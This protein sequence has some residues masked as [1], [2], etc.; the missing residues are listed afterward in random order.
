MNTIAKGL[1]GLESKLR[2]PGGA[3]LPCRMTL[4]Q[5]DDGGLVMHSPIRLDDEQLA[6]IRALGPV[7]HIIAPNLYHHLFLKKAAENFPEAQV[8]LADGLPE[9]IAGLPEGRP[10]SELVASE[11]LE[12]GSLRAFAI[13]GQPKLNEF[14]FYY[15][16]SKALV[17]TDL[18]FNIREP[19]G[20]MTKLVLGMMGTKG[21]FAV[22]RLISAITKDK[23]AAASSVQAL[24]GLDVEC[25][26]P[27]HGQVQHDDARET[28]LQATAKMRKAAAVGEASV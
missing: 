27:A 23:Q 14:V 15:R 5:L 4:C 7:K 25:I 18:V 6:A 1:W 2:I 21:R 8:W 12:G 28:F 17:C 24:C 13:A 26:V 16:A 10:L 11:G 3:A 22:S 19:E 20:F 9:K